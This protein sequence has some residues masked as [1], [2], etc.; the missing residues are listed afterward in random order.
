LFNFQKSD[1]RVLRIYPNG[2]SPQ[3]ESH[4]SLFLS[5]IESNTTN[6][7]TKYRFGIL[8]KTKKE[9]FLSA[10]A[11]RSGE[12]FRKNVR[13]WGFSKFIHHDQLQS[14]D[15]GFIKNDRLTV[16]CEVKVYLTFD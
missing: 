16:T 2:N 13:G 1:F 3:K 12:E 4:V 9:N 11:Q 14:P 10:E 6:F 5:L 15:K 8:G 7:E